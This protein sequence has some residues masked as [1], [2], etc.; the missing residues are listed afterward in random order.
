MQHVNS[1]VVFWTAS[2]EFTQDRVGVADQGVER[3]LVGIRQIS[4]TLTRQ[5]PQL[6]LAEE[7][8]H[9]LFRLSQLGEALLPFHLL[10]VVV[11]RPT[12]MSQHVQRLGVRH[13]FRNHPCQHICQELQTMLVEPATPNLIPDSPE[14]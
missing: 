9:G 4:D 1:V 2:V 5:L 14:Q 3:R 7:A 6:R 13:V 11:Q 8:S 12:G 10:L